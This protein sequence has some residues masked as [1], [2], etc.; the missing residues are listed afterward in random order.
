M[1]NDTGELPI[2]E[3]GP[4]AAFLENKGQFEKEI[5][6][7]MRQKKVTAFFFR[8]GML[9]GLSSGRWGAILKLAYE[10]ANPLSCPEGEKRISD[11]LRFFESAEIERLYPGLPRWERLFQKEVWEGID[12]RIASHEKGFKID[13]IVY[14]GG[15]PASIRIL[16]EGIRDLTVNEEGELVI[17]HPIG[18]LKELS[19]NCYQIKGKKALPVECRHTAVGLASGFAVGKFDPAL[20]L[21]IDPRFIQTGE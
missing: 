5:L 18:Q 19:P 20:P 6:F 12:L 3:I 13:W 8:D 11:K 4:S 9:L 10:E 7:I 21:V 16:W 14:P 1:T 17:T 15:D 2:K